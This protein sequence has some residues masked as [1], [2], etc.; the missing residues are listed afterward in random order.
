MRHRAG[1]AP[2]SPRHCR[3]V[4]RLR[5]MFNLAAPRPLCYF[6]RGESRAK[7]ASQPCQGQAHPQHQACQSHVQ[8][9]F[10]TK[11][12]SSLAADANL[13]APMELGHRPCEAV[14]TGSRSCLHT[15]CYATGA[16]GERSTAPPVADEAVR[17]SN[18]AQ[19]GDSVSVPATMPNGGLP[20]MQVNFGG[21][22]P[23]CYFLRGESRAK[24]AP[25]PCQG[26][27]PPH[28]DTFTLPKA[29][30]CTCNPESRSS[31]RPFSI[32]E[33]A[34]LLQHG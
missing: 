20:L 28:A 21:P 31:R 13:P 24:Q 33:R 22:R 9:G 8:P 17:S 27:H 12:D 6:L 29:E 2:A 16:W 14:L 32:R 1:T 26:P 10:Q 30:Y 23:L 25:L 7:Q 19:S 4:D 15:T 34:F 3:I 18:E 5:C 11:P